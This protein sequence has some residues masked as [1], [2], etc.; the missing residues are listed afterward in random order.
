M[1]DLFRDDVQPLFEVLVLKPVSS[2]MHYWQSIVAHPGAL[3]LCT[4]A[5]L[6][7]FGVCD[8]QAL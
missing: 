2:C 3:F 4:G 1:F 5:V 6:R 7:A 8:A